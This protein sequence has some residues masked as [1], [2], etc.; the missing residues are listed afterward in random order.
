MIKSHA[1]NSVARLHCPA[2]FDSFK[3]YLESTPLKLAHHQ[4]S[5]IEGVLYNQNSNWVTH[6]WRSVVMVHVFVSWRYY[7]VNSQGS[8]WDFF[9]RFPDCRTGPNCGSVVQEV[10]MKT[11]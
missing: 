6:K 4:E 9:Q 1:P 8:P 3:G 11:F 7:T 2:V 10:C 5:I